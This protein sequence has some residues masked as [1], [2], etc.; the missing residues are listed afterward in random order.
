MGYSINPSSGQ[1]VPLSQQY[2]NPKIESAR[3]KLGRRVSEQ[4]LPV[5]TDVEG[6]LSLAKKRELRKWLARNEFVLQAHAWARDKV[7]ALREVAG[8]IEW[9]CAQV[10]TWRPLSGPVE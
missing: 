2:P 9:A 5:E 6:S 7:K 3:L 8:G 4:Q 1:Q 10:A